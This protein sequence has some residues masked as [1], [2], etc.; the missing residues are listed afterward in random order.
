MG[1]ERI[2]KLEAE[3]DPDF[4]VWVTHMAGGERIR[5][6]L[7]C[8]LCSGTCPLSLYMDHTPR[9]LM[10]LAR[11][12]F[13]EE[14]LKSSAIWMCTSCYACTVKCP[15]QINI[16]HL[17]YAFKERAVTEGLYPHRWPIAVMAREFARMVTRSGRIT[18]T[19]LMMRVC[20]QTAIARMFGMRKLGL[21]LLRTGRISFT[22][23]HIERRRDLAAIM[24]SVEE[25][26]KELA[27]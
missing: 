15:K 18:E 19:R 7:Q 22:K 20:L 6:C 9:Q 16:T 8:G 4:A 2:V 26:R 11:E 25:T 12:G 24:H 23:E 1:I 17:L 27:V 3:C 21:A 10:H 5:H 13:K 14:V